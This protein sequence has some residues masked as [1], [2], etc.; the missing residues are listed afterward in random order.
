MVGRAANSRSGEQKS[1]FLLA[2]YGVQQCR[3]SR[4]DM[5]RES[6]LGLLVFLSISRRR[7]NVYS[8]SSNFA[9]LRNWRKAGG[10]RKCISQDVS[11]QRGRRWV[12]RTSSFG[13]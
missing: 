4:L 9:M 1:W 2:R 5:A 6:H 13:L 8:C 12:K 11:E 3:D 7:K 10:G